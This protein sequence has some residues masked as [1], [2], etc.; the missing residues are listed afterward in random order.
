MRCRS[1]LCVFAEF[2][3]SFFCVTALFPF[4][5]FD[6]TFRI[7]ALFPH[8]LFAWMGFIF[9]GFSKM[10]L[11]VSATCP[12]RCILNLQLLVW[13]AATSLSDWSA[14]RRLCFVALGFM[15]IP[16][17]ALYFYSSQHLAKT[18]AQLWAPCVLCHT[19]NVCLFV[20][21]FLFLLLCILHS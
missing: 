14:D 16:C 5:S 9:N 12:S 11:F 7:S 20:C 17:L 2:L 8:L 6:F 15:N 10:I 3:F 1:I 13:Y 18:L 21:Q 19:G 4:Q